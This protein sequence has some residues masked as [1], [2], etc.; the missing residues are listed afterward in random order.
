M[1]FVS[2][3]NRLTFILPL[4]DDVKNRLSGAKYFT[5]IDLRA[6]YWQV[7]CHEFSQDLTALTCS[8]G[9]ADFATRYL[10]DVLIWSKKNI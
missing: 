6:G 7:K 5:S 3:G 2:K 8:R 1:F 4:I 10:D 9:L